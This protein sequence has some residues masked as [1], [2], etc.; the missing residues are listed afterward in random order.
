ML[1]K[2][3]A[4]VNSSLH[5]VIIAAALLCHGF[6]Y[7]FVPSHPIKETAWTQQHSTSMLFAVKEGRFRVFG[8]IGNVARGA[9]KAVLPK[10]W[11]QS[12]EE[13]QMQLTK[14]SLKNDINGNLTQILKDAPRSVRIIGKVLIPVISGIAASATN[15]LQS[16]NQTIKGLVNEQIKEVKREFQEQFEEE[17]R[18]KRRIDLL[19]SDAKIYIMADPT[20]REAL[21]ERIVD[22]SFISQCSNTVIINGN[23]STF[24]PLFQF[25]VVGTKEQGFVAMKATDNGITSMSINMPSR[26]EL[27]YITPSTSST[28][29]LKGLEARLKESSIY[30]PDDIID[31]ELIGP[32]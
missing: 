20:A 8:T 30:A 32:N 7:A 11:T 18:K 29:I 27:I 28:G 9:T 6:C 2:S 14:T 19:L 26:S 4:T 22:V 1:S 5:F 25:F 10:R 15:Q 23:T 12:K 31:V 13:R 17:N 16:Q 21:G 3:I 24:I